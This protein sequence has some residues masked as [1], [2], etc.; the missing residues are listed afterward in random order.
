MTERPVRGFEAHNSFVYCATSFTAQS[1]N[2]YP[3]I[4]RIDLSEQLDPNVLRFAYQSDIYAEDITLGEALAVCHL[5]RTDQLAFICGTISNAV[6]SVGDKGL[7]VQ[8]ATELYPSGWI[9]TGYIRYNTLEQKNFKRVVGR[10]DFTKGSMSIATRDTAGTLYDVNSYDAAIG[11]PESAITQ[12]I[13]AQDAMGLRFTLY[14]DDTTTS[15]GPVFKGYQL[16]SVPASPRERI[17]SVPLLNYDSETD[18]YNSTV[19]YEGRAYDRLAAL[20]NAEST[21]DIVTWQDF[22]TGEINQCLIEE[23]KFTSM[24]PPDKKLTG[25][26]GIIS[27]TIRTV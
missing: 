4:Y 19:G 17:I 8:S 13:G 26:G 15:T 25:F 1:G 9:Q 24:T 2:T 11:N 5:G 12:P 27:L 16:K 23:V 3:G 22:R 6:S 21:G 20:E 18:K 14:R 7:Y 10:G